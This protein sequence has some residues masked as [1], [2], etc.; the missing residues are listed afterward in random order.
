ML[1]ERYLLHAGMDLSDGLALDLSR[2]AVESQVGAVLRLADIPIAPAAERAFKTRAG[3]V[4]HYQLH[5][6]STSSL[7]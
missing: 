6:C 5:P 2:L 3:E 4:E 7:L 1:H